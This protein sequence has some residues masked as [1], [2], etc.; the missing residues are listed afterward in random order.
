MVSMS[1][2]RDGLLD[3]L[4]EKRRIIESARELVAA[5]LSL[6]AIDPVMAEVLTGVLNGDELYDGA[7]LELAEDHV[8]E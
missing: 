7:H 8:V 4:S 5:G 3:A 2:Q 6:Q 1:Y